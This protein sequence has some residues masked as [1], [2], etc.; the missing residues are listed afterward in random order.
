MQ[1][2]TTSQKRSTIIFNVQALNA[3]NSKIFTLKDQ[4]R[5]L[6]ISM[7]KIRKEEADLGFEIKKQSEIV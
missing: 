1:R 2:R 3:N 6:E 7:E 4:L 5:E